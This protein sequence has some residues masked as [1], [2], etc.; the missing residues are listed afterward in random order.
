MSARITSTGL[1][2]RLLRR[3]PGSGLV[4]AALSVL[5]ALA[6]TAVPVVLSTLDDR[7]AQ[8]AVAGLSPGERDLV[9]STAGLPQT[10]SAPGG[11]SVSMP[12]DVADV[13]GAFDAHL[14]EARAGIP[15]PLGALVEPAEYTVRSSAVALNGTDDSVGFLADPRYQDH[16]ELTAGAWPAPFR[17]DFGLD[18]GYA[19]PSAIEIAL[20]DDTAAE[21]GWKVG[22]ERA[23][24]FAASAGKADLP[25]RLV[26]T[27]RAASGS[28]DYWYHLDSVL[29]PAIR[30]QDLAQ[31]TTGT[32]VIAPQSVM[33]L[34][35]GGFRTQVWYP[36][37]TDGISSA[38]V[39]RIAAQLRAFTSAPVTV[40]D[41]ADATSFATI[42]FDTSA[43]PTLERALDTQSAMAA[44]FAITAAGPAGA[45]AAV[46]A[47]ACRVIARNRRPV[48]AL[49][50]ARGA[51]PARLRGLQAWHG[52]WFGS[53][54][55][56]AAAA[57]AAVVLGG[58]RVVSAIGVVGIVGALVVAAL[59]PLILAAVAP[60]GPR[61]AEEVPSEPTRAQR[62]RRLVVEGVVV[63]AAVLA[64]AALV[65]GAVS[66]ERVGAAGSA[67]AS[68]LLVILAPLLAALVG[69]IVALRLLP[70]PLG[71][72]LARLRRRPALTGFLGA[73]RALRE[74][75]VGIAPVLALIIGV[76]SATMSGVLLG[77]V[78]HEVDLSARTTVGAD[79]QIARV[80]L[81]DDLIGKISA[82]PG[83]AAVAPIGSVTRVTIDGRG[84]DH[85]LAT[86]LTVDP[87]RLAAVQDPVAPLAPDPGALSRTGGAVPIVLAAL[88]STQLADPSQVTVGSVDARVVGVSQVTAPVGVTEVWAL[89]ADARV[90]DVTRETPQM[91]NALVR[92]APGADAAAVAARVR[93]AVGP[94]AAVLTAASIRDDL[95]TRTGTEAI[96]V[97]LLVATGAAALFGAIAVVLSLVLSAAARD[98]L[99]GLLR[100]LGS[101]A[102]VGRGLVWWELWPAVAASLVTGVVVGLAVAALLLATVDFGVF[103]DQ[104]PAYHL[105]PLLLG[106]AILGFL[107]LTAVFTVVA[108]ALSRRV[109]AASVLRQTQEG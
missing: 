65:S 19:W 90:G 109:R 106:G 52:F 74:S 13:W 108:L 42:G 102:R 60:P 89:V 33:S 80:A 96:R 73:A 18:S 87:A 84:T 21:L 103:I 1:T 95:G 50:A 94:D 72:L 101:P 97:A 17:I 59:A 58:G 35:P 16:A 88:A 45:A 71:A 53:V 67:S 105:D 37:R 63:A 32:A 64:V 43:V 57:I 11:A 77:S 46:L 48:F 99:F 20:S 8:E 5:L 83:V 61:L 22:E 82:I 69:C 40:G 4:V 9:G 75:A 85:V 24:A 30:Y 38:A 100:A 98:R 91:R 56:L 23:S 76:S 28:D 54:P 68:S 26:G 25:L 10:G 27:F 49:L 7:V 81:S 6:A 93:D 51:S 55:A 36:L 47:V 107:V 78:Q 29:T 104:Q 39:P 31:F 44:V 15:D 79:L 86:L 41:G 62:R 66:G 92:L 2:L 12:D 34:I 14:E 70:V 3:R